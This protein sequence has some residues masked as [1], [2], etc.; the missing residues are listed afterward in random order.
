[1]FKVSGYKS[2][3]SIATKSEEAEGQERFQNVRLGRLH[4][5]FNLPKAVSL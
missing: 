3:D 2:S 4:P 1:M 5:G